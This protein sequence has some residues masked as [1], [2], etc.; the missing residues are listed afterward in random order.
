MKDAWYLVAIRE[1]ERKL[2]H[3]AAASDNMD[4]V[5]FLVLFLFIC[6]GFCLF[7]YLGFCFSFFP[8]VRFLLLLF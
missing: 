3:K 8:L 4:F 7:V 1:G 6:F 5:L 2:F